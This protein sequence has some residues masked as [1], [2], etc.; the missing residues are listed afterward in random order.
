LIEVAVGDSR[1]IAGVRARES[2][3]RNGAKIVGREWSWLK[4][5]R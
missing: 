3:A 1:M 4:R 5:L 2:R